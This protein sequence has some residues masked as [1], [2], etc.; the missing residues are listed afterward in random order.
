M[1]R[2]MK[3][4]TIMSNFLLVMIPK[5]TACGP[6]VGR[7]KAFTGFFPPAFFIAAMYFFWSSV[8]N[9]S[10]GTHRMSPLF[11]PTWFPQLGQLWFTLWYCSQQQNGKQLKQQHL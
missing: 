9:V 5:T 6:H 3:P 7:G 2:P 4:M 10:A 8:M 1:L 11:I